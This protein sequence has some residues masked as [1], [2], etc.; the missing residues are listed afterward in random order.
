MAERREKLI[1]LG[2]KV[3]F[4][5]LTGFHWNSKAEGKNIPDRKWHADRQGHFIMLSH[6]YLTLGT[7]DQ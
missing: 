2:F 6:A 1:L 3:T 4:R 7:G 5:E